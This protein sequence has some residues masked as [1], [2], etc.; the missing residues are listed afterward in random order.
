MKFGNIVKSADNESTSVL[1]SMINKFTRKELT[2]DDVYIIPVIACDNNLDRDMD[3]F[4]VKAL[5]ELADLFV[6]KTVIFDHNPKAANQTARIFHAEVL[7]NEAVKTSDGESLHQLKVYAYMLKG[8]STQEI[9]DS[10]DAGIL[11]EV[12]VNCRVESVLCSVCKK[13]YYGGECSHC[14]G[15]TYSDK[16]CFTYLDGAKDAYELSFVAIPAQPGAGVVKWYDG[17]K[18]VKEGVKTVNYEETKK[19]LSEIGVELD[20]IAK[21]KGIVPGMDVILAAVKSKWDESIEK[22]SATVQE[23]ISADKAKE[24][25]GKEMTAEDILSAAKSHDE[26]ADKAKAYDAIKSAAV[27]KAIENGIKAKGNEFDSE[28]YKKLFDGLSVEEVEKWSADFTEEAKKALNAGF[29]ASEFV[30]AKSHC[31]TDS[32]LNKYK[33]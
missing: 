6:G 30:C 23:F 1:M 29:K 24:F 12:S 14:K 31:M 22:S 7:N 18:S 2:E 21:E 28:R 5:N 9:I 13:E 25:I 19:A 8:E 33:F 3:K 27:D 10:I 11:K 4:T 16:E 26:L 15:N 20:G 17:T 32:E